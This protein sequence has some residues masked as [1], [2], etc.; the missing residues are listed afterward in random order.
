MYKTTQNIEVDR[1]KNDRAD[2]LACFA[3]TKKLGQHRTFLQETLKAPSTNIAEI[4]FDQVVRSG[5][6]FPI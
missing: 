4:L 6:V 2:A 3:N 1:E 5:W